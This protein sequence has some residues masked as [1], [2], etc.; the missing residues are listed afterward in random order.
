MSTSVAVRGEISDALPAKLNGGGLK[1]LLTM[2][3][4]AALIT[5]LL[6]EGVSYQRVIAAAILEG[7]KNPD[8]LKCTPRSIMTAVAKTMQWGLEIGETAYLV[9]FNVNV[10]P[11]GAPKVYEKRLQAVAGYTGLAQLMVAS[12]AIRH[13]EA[14]AVYEGDGF[15]LTHG[16]DARLYHSPIGDRKA[17]GRLKGAYAILHLPFGVKVWDYMPVEDIDEIRQ[18]YSKQWKQGA[19]PAWYAKKTIV[20]QVSKLVPKDPR[21][22]KV[23]AVVSEDAAEEFGAPEVLPSL[24]TGDDDDIPRAPQLTSGE[25][26]MGDEWQEAPTGNQDEAR[27]EDVLMPMGRTKGTR[28]GDLETRDLESASKWMREHEKFPDIVEA[29]GVVLANRAGAAE[30]D[31]LFPGDEAQHDTRIDD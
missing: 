12:R 18:K 30:G 16:T 20:R 24:A 15:E 29:I 23:L 8:I 17:R 5:P 6:P 28:L 22:S 13:V 27:V 26:E 19:C 4:V 25:R 3:Q 7:E 14:H 2:E 10:A 31:S 1:E 9:P 11:Q 21:L